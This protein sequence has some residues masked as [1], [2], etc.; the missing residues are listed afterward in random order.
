MTLQRADGNVLERLHTDGVLDFTPPAD[1]AYTLKLNDL[2]FRGD[3][4]FP[5]AVT[6][7]TGPLVE[8]AFDGGSTWTLY[9]RN[10]PK[11]SDSMKRFGKAFQRVQIPAKEAKHLLALNPVKT[12]RFEAETEAPGADVS[13]PVALKSPA[14]FIGW[15]P[16]RGKPRYF[17]FEAHKGDVLWIEVNSAS[18]GILADPFFT[19]EKAGK[20][21]L[22]F[23]A[24]ANDRVAVAAKDEFDAG[25]ADPSYRFQATEDG[26][27]RVKLRNLFSNA[28]REPFELKVQPVGTGF[29]LVAIPAVL[30]KAKAATTVEVN[31]APLW[32]GGVAT[33]KVFA[34]RHDGFAGPIELSADGLPPGVTFAGG[35]VREGQNIGYASFIA[36]E[37]APNWGGG[38]KLHGKSGPNAIGATAVLKVASTAKEA[39]VTRFTD[40]V[41][42]GVVG[43]DAPVLVQAADQVFEAVAGTKLS[44]PLQVKRRADC[45]EAFKL[46]A[47]DLNAGVA[48]ADIAAKA[49]SGKLDLDL[50]KLKLPAG[51]Y[52]V[53]LQG[54]VKFK[55][56]PGEDAKAAA[57]E[58]TF[59]V[60][61]KPIKMNVKPVEKK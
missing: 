3:G 58:V 52:Q 32:R 2:M 54:T 55:H 50:A 1:G 60:N 10:L 56:K 8:Y 14:H 6:L 5:Y 25:W 31:A 4:E 27:Y 18:R 30:P 22:T 29:D 45:T 33:L 61:S 11:G 57:K 23:I 43:S 17:T 38:V 12:V 44:I 48:E 51:D 16:E 20:D 46:T 42:L 15:F 21:T 53:V 49:T 28:P 9:G 13:K 7:T 35:L 36:D 34:L 47:L 59:L 41:P 26:T 40:E 39:V 19:V 24:E 37:T